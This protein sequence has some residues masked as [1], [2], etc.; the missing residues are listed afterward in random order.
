MF[1]LEIHM[2]NRPGEL[3]RMGRA[4]GAAGVGVE[5]GGM[6]LASGTGIAHF[7]VTDD[8]A[9]LTALAAAG[10]PVAAC[11]EVLTLRLRQDQPG[12]LGA[13]TA[14][15]AEAGVNIET[16]YS[17]HDHRLVLLVDDQE[18][19]ERVQ[20]GWTSGHSS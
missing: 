14:A 18:A 6:F 2:P 8:R 5:G 20:S 1:D 13:L 12:Q 16:L 15:M 3:A 17:D 11:R 9:A 4:L 10:V 19:A 7:L